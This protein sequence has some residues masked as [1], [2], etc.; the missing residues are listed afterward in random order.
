MSRPAPVVVLFDGVC[1][2]CNG[3]VDFA[4]ARDPRGRLRFGALQSEEGQR[5][6]HEAGVD[7]PRLS[8]LV[9]LEGGTAYVRSDAALRALR[10]LRFP[11]PLLFAAVVV[12][13]PLRDAVYAFVAARRY[14]WFGRR[15]TC[16]LP[17]SEE[18]A[19][20]LS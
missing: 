17:S 6:L 2:L 9:V 4:I 7:V 5:A 14:R 15:D 13:R 12:P 19:R 16:R 1:N 3:F 18:R 8:T 20:F 11:W 10:Q